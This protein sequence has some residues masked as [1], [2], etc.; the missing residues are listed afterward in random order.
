LSL[1]WHIQKVKGLTLIEVLIA[2]AII[3]IAM[4]AVIKTS[5]QAIS[6]TGY[7]EDKMVATWVAQQILNEA[8][9]GLIKLTDDAPLQ[10]VTKSLGKN[11][12][13]KLIKKE[14]ANPRIL[15]VI[16]S[17]FP[18]GKKEE[19]DETPIVSLEGYVYQSNKL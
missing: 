17:V 3:S 8:R 5:G 6:G 9:V 19:D 16:V 12:H 1:F 11:W 10:R 2:L 7:L 15:Q 4:T 13:S 18:A 14:T